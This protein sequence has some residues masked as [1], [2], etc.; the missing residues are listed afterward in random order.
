MVAVQDFD[1]IAVLDGNDR[2]G[3]VGGKAAHRNW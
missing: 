1:G 3:V 2:G